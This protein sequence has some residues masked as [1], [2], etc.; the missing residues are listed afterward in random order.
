MPADGTGGY[1]A[2]SGI[3]PRRGEGRLD[4]SPECGTW[5]TI[6]KNC[7]SKDQDCGHWP[8]SCQIPHRKQS[9]RRYNGVVLCGAALGVEL[10]QG[11][12]LNP[13]GTH[14]RL[15]ST[16]WSLGAA[17]LVSALAL[18]ACSSPPPP[19]PPAPVAPVVAPVAPAPAP[20]M[21][22]HWRHHYHHH[23]HKM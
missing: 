7:R 21:K 12:G 14:M 1:E 10:I 9:G 20:M 4:A 5:V 2:D 13:R 3:A 6:R 11:I 15:V 8:I 16:R 19:P 22:H 17:A 18:A 23:H